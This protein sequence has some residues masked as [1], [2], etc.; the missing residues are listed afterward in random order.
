MRKTISL[1][2]NLAT[3]TAIIT[4]SASVSKADPVPPDTPN[5]FC[6]RFTDIELVLGTSKDFIVEFEVL[7]WTN[8]N[9]YGV[10]LSS[11]VATNKIP[12]IGGGFGNTTSVPPIISN[13]GID[14]DGRG[15]LVGGNDIPLPNGTNFGANIFDEIGIHSGRG[16]GDA[17]NLINDWGITARTNTLAV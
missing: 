15:G 1:L 11:T 16:R 5:I 3:T 7:N 12:L 10:A 14:S 6:F 4:L 13:I 17:P 8:Q 2:A 9:A